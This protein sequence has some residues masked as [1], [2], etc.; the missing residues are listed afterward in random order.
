[1]ITLIVLADIEKRKIRKV[2]RK[3]CVER[4][5]ITLLKDVKIRKRFDEKVTELVDVGAPNLWGH[6]MNGVL[7]SGDEVCWKIFGR[8][9]KGDSCWWNEDVKEVVSGKKEEHKAMC[10][11]STEENK[12]RYN[13]MKNKAVSKA[14]REKAEELLPELQNCPNG[15]FRPVKGLKTDSR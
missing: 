2:V 15:M 5:K 14:M 11:N 3:T 13:G 12:R 6:F 10:Q 1:M 8:K 4:R 9:S 7:E